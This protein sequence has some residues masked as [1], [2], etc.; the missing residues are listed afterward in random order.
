[1]TFIL[2]GSQAAKLTGI[3]LRREAKDFDAFADFEPASMDAKLD[4]FW[5]PSFEAIWPEGTDRFAH[6]DELYTIKISHAYFDLKNGQ[7]RKHIEDAMIMKDHY[8]A[9]LDFGM[10]QILKG[11]W[12]QRYG[13]KPMSLQKDKQQFFRDAVVRRYDHDS[14]H[15]SVAYGEEPMYLRVLKDGSTV[16]VDMGKLKALDHE[17]KLRLF[18][19]EVYAT[20]LERILVPSDYAKSPTGAYMWALR[21]TIT[22]L[23]KGWSARWLAEHFDEMKIIDMDYVARHL[24]RKDKLIKLEEKNG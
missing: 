6:L 22:S 24:S 13:T 20:A 15:D 7:W 4:T 1:V 10:H 16:D 9:E 3:D 18:R 8:G 17:D 2:I 12:Q 14:L 21:R 5:H 19:E 23:T 11:V